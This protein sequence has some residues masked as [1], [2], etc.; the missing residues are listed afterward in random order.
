M[1]ANKI[2]LGVNIDHVATVRQ[3][4]RTVYPD[5]AA[6]AQ[7]AIQNGADSITLHLREDRRHIQDTD[8]ENL[9][10]QLTAPLNLEMAVTE[11]ML[12]FAE[13]IQPHYCCL[14]PEKRDELTTE[15]GLD[16]AKNTLIIQSACERLTAKG[17]TVSLFIGPSRQQIEAA[18]N[19]GAPVIEIHTGEYANHPNE[20]EWQRLQDAANYANELGL[21]VNAGHGIDYDNIATLKKIPHLNELNIGHSIVAKA[22]FIGMGEAVKLMKQAMS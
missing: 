22:L 11:E 3:V 19:C 20:E 15:G 14:V 2:K 4:R 8:V 17:I 16:I 5:P 18:K 9:K 6:A 13:K 7:I 21:I 12:N 1:N 10:K